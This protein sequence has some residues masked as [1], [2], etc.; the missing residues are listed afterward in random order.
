MDS[1]K[2]HPGF[3]KAFVNPSI[4]YLPQH[5]VAISAFRA[6]YFFIIG[7][8]S[9]VAD[10]HQSPIGIKAIYDLSAMLKTWPLPPS[11]DQKFFGTIPCSFGWGTNLMVVS[12]PLMDSRH[13]RIRI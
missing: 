5:S 8:Q 12:Q 10:P 3:I 13:R 4:P 9:A 11:A 2:L 7:S 1:Q 6:R